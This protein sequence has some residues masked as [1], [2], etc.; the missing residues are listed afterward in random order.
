MASW[1][2]YLDKQSHFPTAQ[3]WSLVHEVAQRTQRK[4]GCLPLG[5]VLAVPGLVE[6]GDHMARAAVGLPLALPGI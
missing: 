6:S 4:L 2:D 1:L 5:L 3:G